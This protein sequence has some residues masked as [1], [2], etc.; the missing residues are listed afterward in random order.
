MGISRR[1]F[2]ALL[3]ICWTAASLSSQEK[4]CRV[5]GILGFEATP[6]AGP[7]GE[8]YIGF[9]E[10]FRFSLTVLLETHLEGSWGVHGYSLSVAHDGDVLEIS[11]ATQ[12]GT[13]AAAVFPLGFERVEILDNETGAGF[14]CAVVLSLA[15]PVSLPPEGVFSLARASYRALAAPAGP[16]GISTTVEFLDGLRGSGQ[17]VRNTL[18][19]SGRSVS[20]CVEPFSLRLLP[21]P[22]GSFLRGDSDGSGSLDI[23]DAVS[24]IHYL[25]LDASE[26][27]CLDAVDANDDGRV[28]IADPIFELDFLFRGGSSPPPPFPGVGPDPTEDELTCHRLGG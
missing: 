21:Q 17:P 12:E 28:D 4:D 3:C 22:P 14:V 24:T 8:Y 23:S 5:S 11:D 2:I 25:F 6:P 1:R 16:G 10:D 15:Q 19:L 20:P 26:P 7:R 27:D 18:T 13:D 9:E